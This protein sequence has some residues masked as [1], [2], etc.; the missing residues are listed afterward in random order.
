MVDKNVVCWP[1]EIWSGSSLLDFLYK[2][3]FGSCL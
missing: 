3:D 2:S 1:H